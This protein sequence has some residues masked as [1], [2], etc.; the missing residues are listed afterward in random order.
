[1]RAMEAEHGGLV[2]AMIAKQRAARRARAAAGAGAGGAAAP[3]SPRGGPAGPG[4]RLTSFRGGM[5]ELPR[6][7]ATR[8]GGRVRLGARV[9]AV[10][11]SSGALRL[12][13]AS[14]E[15]ETFDLVLLACPP[16]EAAAQVARLDPDLSALL[17]GIPSAPVAVVALGFRLADVAG[18][19]DGFGFLVPR[20]EGVRALGALFDSNIFPERAPEGRAL[21]RVLAG[22]SRD[23]DAVA[24]DDGALVAL[25]RGLLAQACGVTEPPVLE[26]VIRH[27]LGIPQYVQ[28]HA[29]RLGAIESRLARH[30][31][32]WLAGNAYDG[33]SV[34]ACVA[35]V[36]RL[37]ASLRAAAA[38]PR[39]GVAARERC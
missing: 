28:G 15:I 4:G 36:P 18:R 17:A 21:V 39:S 5:E 14:G 22:G 20:S 37:A 27:R 34:N 9:A 2:R 30:R 31:G 3:A 26:R 25:A 24:L 8:L 38:S 1:M 10:E 19:L 23:P 11:A 7:L 13:L 29:A 33:I 6:A 35:A 32:L 12:R 16:G